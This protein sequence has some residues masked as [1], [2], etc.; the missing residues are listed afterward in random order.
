V[1][2]VLDSGTNWEEAADEHA[3]S[4][5]LFSSVWDDSAWFVGTEQ[6]G[7]DGFEINGPQFLEFDD[8]FV[9]QVFRSFEQTPTAAGKQQ[10][11]APS[12]Q[13]LCL[14]GADLVDGFAKVGH[15]MEAVDD[16]HSLTDNLGNDS[17]IRFPNVAADKTESCGPFF[18]KF[19]EESPQG[20]LGPF[21]SDPQQALAT[22]SV[23]IW[24]ASRFF[25][26]WPWI[27]WSISI[28]PKRMT[29]CFI[30]T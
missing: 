25:P 23:Y 10:F 24:V 12:F 4:W 2:L 18:A 29:G 6:I 13:L 15:D 16:L 5:Q 27:S 28:M 8:L 17:Q 9:G 19:L 1:Q 26:P 11:F 30:L 7:P 14:C 21:L 22:D 20:F 3:T